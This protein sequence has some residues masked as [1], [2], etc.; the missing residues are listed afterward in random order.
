MKRHKPKH[1]ILQG[2]LMVSIDTLS[3]EFGVSH[4]DILG[5]PGVGKDGLRD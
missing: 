1:L 2:K 3:S 5:D 4:F